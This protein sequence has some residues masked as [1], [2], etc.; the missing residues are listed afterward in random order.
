MARRPAWR[1][2]S[3]VDTAPSIRNCVGAVT[4]S[5]NAVRPLGIVIIELVWQDR[6]WLGDRELRIRS[7]DPL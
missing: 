5:T 3:A 6:T 1:D 2:H 4:G 7:G